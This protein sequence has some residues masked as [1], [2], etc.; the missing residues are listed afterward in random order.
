MGLEKEDVNKIVLAVFILIVSVYFSTAVHELG[1]VLVD[2]TNGCK[3][4]F[5]WISFP[6]PIGYTDC[7][8]PENFHDNLTNMQDIY[9]LG[10]GPVFAALIGLILLLLYNMKFTNNYP[11]LSLIFYFF[12]FSA[13]SNG[14]LQMATSNDLDGMVEQGFNPIYFYIIA[15]ILGIVIIIQLWMFKGL[16][17][18]V[19]PKTNI[20]WVKRWQ[21]SWIV[22]VCLYFVIYFGQ[23]ILFRLFF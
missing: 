17:K 21:W 22:L 12:S 1:H 15:L 13:I 8:F 4:P 9:L 16:I 5:A 20:K 14:F 2:F 18:R 19:S 3:A 23:G 6:I 10:A 11:S 7:E